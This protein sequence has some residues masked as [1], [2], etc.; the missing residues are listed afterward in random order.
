TANAYS[1]GVSEEITGRALREFT[2]RD[3]VV[4]ATKVFYGMRTDP[5]APGL[6]RKAILAEIDSSLSRLNMDYVDL[7]QTHWPDHG[8][9]YEEP[10]RALEALNGL[11]Q[12]HFTEGDYDKAVQYGKRAVELAP[13]RGAYRIVEHNCAILGVAMKYG[14]ACG[15]ELEF[16]RAA[17]PDTEIQRV[18]HIIAGA[19]SCAYEVRPITNAN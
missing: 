8:T 16:I 9:S 18:Q 3:E 19:F 1:E 13:G 15:S 5:N 12:V 11:A 6:S 2:R 7:Y 4:V 14:Q 10:M 17:L